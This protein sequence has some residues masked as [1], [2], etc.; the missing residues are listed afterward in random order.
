MN[1]LTKTMNKTELTKEDE[2]LIYEIL[3]EMK[4]QTIE[5]MKQKDKKIKTLKSDLQE[6]SDYDYILYINVRLDQIEKEY[7]TISDYFERVSS[8]LKKVKLNKE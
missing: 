5:R 7:K 2:Q 4:L 8:V 3:F 6:A 1:L